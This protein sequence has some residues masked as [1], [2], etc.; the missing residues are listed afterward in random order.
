MAHWNDG[1]SLVCFVFGIPEKMPNPS[2]GFCYN[3]IETHLDVWDQRVWFTFEGPLS[4][5]NAF[6]L[7]PFEARALAAALIRI[8]DHIDKD[9]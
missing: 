3:S 1:D 4:H 5:T 8:A 9:D 6:A 2:D 7:T